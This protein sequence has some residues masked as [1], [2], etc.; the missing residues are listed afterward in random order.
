MTKI[1]IDKFDTWIET[2]W[3][4]FTILGIMIVGSISGLIIGG[5]N[6]SF[7]IGFT[8]GTGIVFFGLLLSDILLS[9]E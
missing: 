9:N 8:A 1:T 5:N 4:I 3:G 7:L 2:W 6:E